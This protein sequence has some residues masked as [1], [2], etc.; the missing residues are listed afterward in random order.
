MAQA[1][2]EAKFFRFAASEAEAGK[3]RAEQKLKEMKEAN[4]R[5]SAIETQ[6]KLH[7]LA[8]GTS[9]RPSSGRGKP[10]PQY[11]MCLPNMACCS[12]RGEPAPKAHYPRR[13]KL[14]ARWNR[15]ACR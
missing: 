8:R 5:L 1:R 15:D 14:A 11:G 9:G 4:V 2:E 6:T 3:A 7:D 13:Y 12:S 10:A